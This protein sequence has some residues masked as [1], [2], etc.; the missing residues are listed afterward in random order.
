[1][2]ENLDDSAETEETNVTPFPNRLQVQQ[3]LTITLTHNP[4]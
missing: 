4:L 3:A 1:M 2:K